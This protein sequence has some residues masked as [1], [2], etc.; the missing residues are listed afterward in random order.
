MIKHLIIQCSTVPCNFL[1][2]RFKYKG[3]D[4]C[5]RH[6]HQNTKYFTKDNHI[7]YYTVYGATLVKVASISDT[8]RFCYDFFSYGTAARR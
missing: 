4:L 3:S 8:V 2:L 5:C 6:V 1:V 7:C